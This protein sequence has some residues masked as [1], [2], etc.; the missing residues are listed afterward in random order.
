LLIRDFYKTEDSL[1]FTYHRIQAQYETVFDSK[2]RAIISREYSRVGKIVKE[3]TIN[4]DT[5]F[6]ILIYYHDNGA[7]SS[8]MY[9]LDG[10]TFGHYQEYDEKGFP[11]RGWD[12]DKDGEVIKDK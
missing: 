11:E 9:T 12:Y 3:E 1:I 5:K 8:I 10:K 4:P 2:G 7:I 6:C